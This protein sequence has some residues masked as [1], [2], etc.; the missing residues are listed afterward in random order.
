MLTQNDLQQIRGVVQE[1]L[2]PVKTSV[3]GLQKDMIEVK[4]SVAGLQKDMIE[5]KK[6]IRK[7]KNSQDT[8]VSFFDHSYLELEKRVT[9]VEHHC[10]LPAMV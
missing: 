9:R 3:S 6:D 1:E 5:V 2:K 10:Q 4:G 8:I 7:V